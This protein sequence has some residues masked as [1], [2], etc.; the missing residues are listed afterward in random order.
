[1]LQL[2]PA[3]GRGEVFGGEAGFWGRGGWSGQLWGP[4]PLGSAGFGVKERMDKGSIV[5]T[6][7]CADIT[8]F[9]PGWGFSL[10]CPGWG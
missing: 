3:V 5:L 2:L 10:G 7:C 8:L 4:I 6:W 1:M 9:G